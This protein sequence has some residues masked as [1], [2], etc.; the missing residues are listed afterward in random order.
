MR[1][2]G[3]HHCWPDVNTC[4]ISVPLLVKQSAGQDAVHNSC[5][6]GGNVVVLAP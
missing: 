4:L 1:S 5:Q 6:E 3:R 2:L